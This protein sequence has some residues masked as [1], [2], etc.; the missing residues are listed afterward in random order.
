M[1]KLKLLFP[2]AFVLLAMMSVAFVACDDKEDDTD[3]ASIGKQAAEEYCECMDIT[4]STN[5]CDKELNKNY[6]ITEK[7]V[8]AF[9]AVSVG[10]CKIKL[11]IEYQ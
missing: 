10:L 9:N 8:E 4:D 11:T 6:T 5:E 1:K 3:Y 2:V 7:F